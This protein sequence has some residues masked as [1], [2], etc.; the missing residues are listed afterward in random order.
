MPGQTTAQ[1]PATPEASAAPPAA[2]PA[3]PEALARVRKPAKRLTAAEKREKAVANVD[4]ELAKAGLSVVRA[5]EGLV[6][7]GKRDAAK[8]CLTIWEQLIDV[9][10][11]PAPNGEQPTTSEA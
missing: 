11:E 1:R 6:A 10:S 8:R 4:A 3:A 5:A 7:A 9:T 2:P